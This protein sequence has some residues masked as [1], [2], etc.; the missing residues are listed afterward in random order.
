MEF[1]HL[2]GGGG[3]RKKRAQLRVDN[4]H[5]KSTMLDAS[6]SELNGDE[7]VMGLSYINTTL[8]RSSTHVAMDPN[9][10]LMMER[11]KSQGYTCVK[12]VVVGAP[13]TGKTKMIQRYLD[14]AYEVGYEPT[15][16]GNYSAKMK[17]YERPV[18]LKIIEVGGQ[19]SVKMMR[20]STERI[21]DA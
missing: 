14:N 21:F 13:R 16:I 20:E 2:K 17:I 1:T 15:Q 6:L 18:N 8:V 3:K 10:S 7:A 12:L 19:S 5:D 4:S 11:N 9:E